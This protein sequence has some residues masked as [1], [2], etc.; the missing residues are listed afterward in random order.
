MQIYQTA[1]FRFKK[2][3]TFHM[4]KLAYAIERIKLVRVARLTTGAC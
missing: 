2:S 3:V 1:M 4:L